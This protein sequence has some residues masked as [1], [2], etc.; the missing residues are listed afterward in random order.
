MGD[1][2]YCAQKFPSQRGGHN[3]KEWGAN[4]VLDLLECG[5]CGRAM[6]GW[7]G[8]SGPAKDGGAGM[9]DGTWTRGT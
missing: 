7:F 1:T 6:C 9:M 5:Y 4:Q 8:R 3:C 2:P